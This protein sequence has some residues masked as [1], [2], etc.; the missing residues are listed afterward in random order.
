[1]Q[2]NVSPLDEMERCVHKKRWLGFLYR[3]EAKGVPVIPT[4]W[5]RLRV[6]RQGYP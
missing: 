1:M 5:K 6:T 3:L 4:V 2:A